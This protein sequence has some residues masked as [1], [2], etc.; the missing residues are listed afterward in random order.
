MG[1]FKCVRQWLTDL[2]LM[3]G[4]ETVDALSVVTGL[5]ART[6]QAWEDGE[7]TPHSKNRAILILALGTEAAVRLMFEDLAAAAQLSGMENLAVA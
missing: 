3:R 7:T 4:F 1:H 2:R 6:I 5:K